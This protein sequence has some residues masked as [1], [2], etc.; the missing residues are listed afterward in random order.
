MQKDTL[1]EIHNHI[2]NI[3]TSKRAEN[4]KRFF[5]CQPGEYGEGDIFVGLT[6]PQTRK[7]LKAYKDLS[8]NDTER[9]LKSKVHEERFLALLIFIYKF[10][11]GNKKEK[12]N[13]FNLYLKNIK[14]INS[15]DM[16]DTSAP[17]IIGEYLKLKYSLK[18]KNCSGVRFLTSLASD[19]S[20]LEKDWKEKLWQKRIAIISTFAF[21]LKPLKTDY[22]PDIIFEVLNKIFSE[23]DEI[24]NHDLVQK[25]SGWMLREYGKRVDEKKLKEFLLDNFE[26]IKDKRILLRYAIERMTREERYYWLNK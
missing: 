6:I 7:I 8:I 4:N 20:V 21:M 11:K 9:L 12:E 2:L 17:K 26:K 3:S 19:K 10:E 15:W 16:I 14:Y 23:K 24:N 18:S 5:K 1:K 25:A 13:I 22:A